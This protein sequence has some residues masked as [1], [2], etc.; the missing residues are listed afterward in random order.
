MGL[1]VPYAALER[2]ARAK[3]PKQGILTALGDHLDDIEVMLNMVLVAVYIR[4]ETTAGG[5]IR[6]GE[7]LAEDIWQGKSGLV[8]KLGPQAFRHPD[9][10]GQEVEVGD[11][12]AFRINDAWQ[13]FVNDVPCRLV[14]DAAIK[15]RLAVPS[16]VF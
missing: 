15:L 9:F 11:W 2:L 12:C 1:V 14:E 13:L 6:P 10:E 16:R 5:I 4:P 3:D 8:V 7:N